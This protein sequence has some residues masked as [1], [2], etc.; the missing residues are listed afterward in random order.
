M[1][2][3]KISELP[4]ATT[5]AGPD[6]FPVVQGGVTKQAAKT[7]LL[8]DLGTPSA[9]VLTNATGLPLTTGVTGTLPVANG[10]TGVTSSTGTGS[11]VLSSGPTLAAFSATGNV[12]FDG[13]SFVF[14]ESGADK[15]AR[16][17]GDTDANLLF[18]DASTD[19]VGIGTATPA[20]KLHLLDASAVNIELRIGNSQSYA[21]VI[22]NSVGEM[23]L[24]TP[25]TAMTFSTNGN[26]QMRITSA[27]NV[28]IGTTVPGAKLDIQGSAGVGLRIF[29]TSTG[30][31]KRL[32][33]TQES[34]SVVY[35]ATVGSGNNQ[36][37]W[38]IGNTE[39]MRLDSSGNLGVGTATPTQRL[40]VV[41][42][43]ATIAK[44]TRDLAT[45][46]SLTIG[47]DNDGAIIGTDGV[48]VMR[49]FTGNTERMRLD[50]S[51]NLFCQ[52][53]YDNTSGSA[54]NVFVASN[55][56]LQRSTS[57]LK[58][59]TDVK[60]A[61]HG[62]AEVMRL[63]PVTYKGKNDGDKVFGGLIAEEVHAAGLTEFVA[64]N[65]AGEPDALHYGNMVA[66]LT[67]AI[68]EQQALITD[69]R[70]RVAALEAK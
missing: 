13:G 38:Q 31:S 56:L 44:F 16:F 9:V 21:S 69:L 65:D 25:G 59:K 28:G 50:S 18:L 11:V 54:A 46:V 48:N 23:Q 67:K 51:G 55:G 22:E 7:V 29:E 61:S 52:G 64:Y 45:D 26:E 20:T 35:N 39:Y 62:L 30:T 14:N 33:I 32:Q 43:S 40:D 34:A 8:S 37:I 3:V 36:H 15:D 6:S 19:R 41:T 17:E 70:A 47:A 58:Y 66:L 5:V 27:G 24:F 4:V 60:N 49:M 68:Q 42:T 12:S 57:S 53:V 10:G 2:N 1:A 63:R